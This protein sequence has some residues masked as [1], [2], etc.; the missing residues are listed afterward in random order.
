MPGAWQ[1]SPSS[2]S[3]LVLHILEQCEALLAA[4]YHLPHI[5][6]ARRRPEHLASRNAHAG[7]ASPCVHASTNRGNFMLKSRSS[8]SADYE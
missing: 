2:S 8:H 5:S 1:H 4:Q 3:K 7:V 6:S